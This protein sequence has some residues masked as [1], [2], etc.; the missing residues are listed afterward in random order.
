MGI[1]N[2]RKGVDLRPILK[3]HTQDLPPIDSNLREAGARGDDLDFI[4]GKAVENGN[5][6]ILA[7]L[8]KAEVLQILRTAFSR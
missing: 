3:D 6:G 5:L 8:G 4:A 2:D 7:S 1:R